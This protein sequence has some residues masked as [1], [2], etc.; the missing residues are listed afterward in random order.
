MALMS[1]NTAKFSYCL[2]ISLCE[3]ND[4]TGSQRLATMGQHPRQR[5]KPCRLLL[6]TGIGGAGNVRVT[7]VYQ[8]PEGPKLGW[9]PKCTPCEDVADQVV[10][11][12]SCRGLAETRRP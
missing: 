12:P 10:Q 6:R 7:K 1:L 11:P 5:T 8:E 2:E 3:G 9:L 4:G